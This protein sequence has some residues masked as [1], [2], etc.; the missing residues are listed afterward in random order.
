MVQQTTFPVC[1]G[2][3]P[4]TKLARFFPGAIAMRIRLRVSMA[5]APAAS[6]E[7]VIEFGTPHEVLFSSRLPLE[8]SDHVHLNDE[9]GSFEEEA[10][11][12][13]VQYHEGATAV[14]VR[15]ERE[16]QHWIVKQ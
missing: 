12:V 7:A 15:F 14:A 2:E 1:F 9:S 3:S 11:V 16:P 4:V 6:D 5:G 13:A 8:F 10:I